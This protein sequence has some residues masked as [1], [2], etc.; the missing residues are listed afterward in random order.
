ME[1]GKAILKYLSYI[2]YIDLLNQKPPFLMVDQVITLKIGQEIWGYKR[3]GYEDFYCPKNNTLPLF[4]LVEMMGQL[5]EILI[6]VT[7]KKH[8]RKAFLA[9]INKLTVHEDTYRPGRTLKIYSRLDAAF[10]GIYRSVA[11]VYD[12]KIK[13]AGATLVHAFD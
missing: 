8:G 10:N 12:R 13:I 1:R 7:D 5:S 11:T 3:F 9:A 2:D 6:R 4:S